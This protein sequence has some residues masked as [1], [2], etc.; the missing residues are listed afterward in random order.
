MLNQIIAR[1][2]QRVEE[3][4]K[5]LPVKEILKEI[6]K[7][8]KRRDFRKAIASAGLSLIAEIKQRSPS[9]G[10]FRRKEEFNYLEIARIYEQEGAKAISVLTEE[11]FFGGSLS[12][13]KEI[14]EAISL[15]ILCKDFI[16]DEYQIYQSVFYGADAVLL[17]S[18]LLSEREIKRF[19]N[20]CEEFG[21][22]ALVEV[23]NEQ[24]IKKLVSTSAKIIGINNRD[25]DTLQVNIK[26]TENLIHLIPPDKLIVSESGIRKKE[27]IRYLRDL[28]VDAVLIGEAFLQAKDIVRR[29][30]EMMEE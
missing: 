16:I 29:I 3:A 1:K 28:G 10:E 4:K 14:K 2:K 20:L 21:I 19:L 6:E 9:F 5:L 15:P 22:E 17:I 13:L 12:Y 25:L 23:H 30:R 24:D 26:T 11:E 8:K 27:D 7:K 18:R